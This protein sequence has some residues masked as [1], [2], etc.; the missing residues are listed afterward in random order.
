MVISALKNVQ[1]DIWKLIKYAKFV[2]Q[3]VLHVIKMDVYLVNLL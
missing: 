3:I 1:M 2:I